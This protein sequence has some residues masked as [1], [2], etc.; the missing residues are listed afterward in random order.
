MCFARQLFAFSDRFEISSIVCN[1]ICASLLKLVLPKDGRW[2]SGICLGAYKD[3]YKRASADQTQEHSPRN[4]FTF[5]ASVYALGEK[6]DIASVKSA[7]EANFTSYYWKNLQEGDRI[8]F[9]NSVAII[10]IGI[11][12]SSD[13]T[14]RDFMVRIIRKEVRVKELSSEVSKSPGL[15]MHFCVIGRHRLSCQTTLRGHC[16]PNLHPYE[17]SQNTQ[18]VLCRPW[19]PYLSLLMMNNA[20]KK[21]S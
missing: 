9:F 5:N 14:L 10:F 2:C 3:R 15:S 17:T 12:A 1:V 16:L 4:L 19:S 6:Y 20:V 18:I 13:R 11:P 21:D 8:D 7:A